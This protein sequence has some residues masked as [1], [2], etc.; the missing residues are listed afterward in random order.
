MVKTKRRC[1]KCKRKLDTNLCK[2]CLT[3]S[4]AEIIAK[5]R[6]SEEYFK[7]YSRMNKKERNEFYRVIIGTL[8]YARTIAMKTQNTILFE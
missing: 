5:I 8:V 7:Q 6:T 3:I 4:L 2:R 1:I